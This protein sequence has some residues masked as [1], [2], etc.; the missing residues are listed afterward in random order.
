MSPNYV[1]AKLD[2]EDLSCVHPKRCGEVAIGGVSMPA[3]ELR[4]FK[5][6]A[7]PDGMDDQVVLDMKLHLYDAMRLARMLL[8]AAE[9]D[10][11]MTW[12]FTDEGT[13]QRVSRLQKSKL[14]RLNANI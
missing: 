13:L 1:R 7:T 8:V 14:E 5:K 10:D 6:I 9:P 11:S 3:M 2:G 12:V 4:G